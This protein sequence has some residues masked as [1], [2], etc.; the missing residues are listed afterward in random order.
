MAI[1]VC[2][3]DKRKENR[4]ME[5]VNQAEIDLL[6]YE[7]LQ[8][9]LNKVFADNIQTGQ[10]KEVIPQYEWNEKRFQ[11]EKDY[12]LWWML[13]PTLG[14][15][16]K[17]NDQLSAWNV[18]KLSHEVQEIDDDEEFTPSWLEEIEQ[19]IRDAVRVGNYSDFGGQL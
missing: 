16:Y 4:K 8:N 10:L 13:Q 1:L 11:E 7:Y 9:E 2:T 5:L 6:E 17:F 3:I 18:Y 19:T 12:F 14:G 15:K